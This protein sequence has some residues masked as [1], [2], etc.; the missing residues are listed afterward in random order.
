M[1][2]TDGAEDRSMNV[3][4]L[5]KTSPQPA[6]SAA[7][8]AKPAIPRP[9]PVEMPME[10]DTSLDRLLHAYQSRVTSA[11]S[12]AALVLAF[13]DWM[14]HFAA[15]PGHR[16]ALAD[17]GARECMRLMLHLQQHSHNPE[18]EPC[19]KSA[20]MDRRFSHAAWKKPPYNALYQSFL[21]SLLD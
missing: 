11:M 20:L 9:G 6:P 4:A 10:R 15:A 8:A 14:M 7:S 2:C 1:R 16:L 12:P 19:V 13:T 3:V 18:C 21:A 17:K 5:P